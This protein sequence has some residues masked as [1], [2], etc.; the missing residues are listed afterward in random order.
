MYQHK[1]GSRETGQCLD[2]IAESFSSVTAIWF[3]LT[4]E[5]ERQNQEVIATVFYSVPQG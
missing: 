5:L 4:K 1:D 2:H 3:K